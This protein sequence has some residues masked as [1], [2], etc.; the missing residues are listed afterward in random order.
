[1][2]DYTGHFMTCVKI[3]DN[4]RYKLWTQSKQVKIYDK[5]RISLN[6]ALVSIK[7]AARPLFFKL[8][9][10]ISWHFVMEYSC[11]VVVDE[12]ASIHT[13]KNI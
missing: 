13:A 11:R 1:M 6:E 9:R 8:L 5:L 2:V 4:L 7:P 3:T 10:S 12:D